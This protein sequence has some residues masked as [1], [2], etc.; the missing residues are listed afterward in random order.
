MS[1][2]AWLA[3]LEISAALS[4]TSSKTA[5]QRTWASWWAPTTEG[6]LAIVSSRSAGDGLRRDSAG[7]RTSNPAALASLRH[8]VIDI[9]PG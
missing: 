9:R 7:I 1:G 4:S 3:S 2:R 6:S 8:S 5:D